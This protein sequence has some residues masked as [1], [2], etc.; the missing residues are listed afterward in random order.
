MRNMDRLNDHG[1][2]H[3]GAQRDCFYFRAEEMLRT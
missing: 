1:L 3:R 2:F